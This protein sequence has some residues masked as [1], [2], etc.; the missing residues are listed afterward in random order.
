[1]DRHRLVLVGPAAVGHHRPRRIDRLHRPRAAQYLAL[2]LVHQVAVEVDTVDVQPL[3]FDRPDLN[4]RVIPL[5]LHLGRHL[6]DPVVHQIHLDLRAVQFLQ[7]R[8][9]FNRHVA[10]RLAVEDAAAADRHAVA[11]GPV[12]RLVGRHAEERPNAAL[13]GSGHAHRRLV[14][15]AVIRQ[16]LVRR[17]PVHAHVPAAAAHA[18]EGEVL[19]VL[20]PLAEAEPGVPHV[21]RL[22]VD[23]HRGPQV[24]Q[25]RVVRPPQ[26][27]IGPV[28]RHFDQLSPTGVHLE[29]HAGPRFHDPAR[30]GVHGGTPHLARHRLPRRV[31]HRHLGRQMLLRHRRLGEHV[32]GVGRAGGGQRWRGEDAGLHRPPHRI[33]EVL[34]PHAREVGRQV[35]LLAQLHRPRRTG[36]IAVPVIPYSDTDFVDLASL[37]AGGHVDVEAD[38]RVFDE[39]ARHAVDDDGGVQAVLREGEHERSAGQRRRHA[40]ARAIPQPVGEQQVGTQRVLVAGHGDRRPVRARR[41]VADRLGDWPRQRLVMAAHLPRPLQRNRR[42]FGRRFGTGQVEDVPSAFSSAGVRPLSPGFSRL[43]GWNGPAHRQKQSEA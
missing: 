26:A 4:R 28:A 22:A 29:R 35:E 13:G 32:G 20:P 23:R 9:G 25:V 11:V 19:A 10:D 31:G 40:N 7:F 34:K 36:G 3:I 43:R 18:V 1:M 41:E 8:I 33:G 37:D 30:R 5:P 42:P 12:E 24:V 6:L 14:R 15:L 21:D 16:P 17:R 27:R 38:E 39:T 2:E